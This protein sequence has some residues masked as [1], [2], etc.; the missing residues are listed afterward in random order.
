MNKS[1]VLGQLKQSDVINDV[2][3]IE[4]K[5]EFLVVRF[6]YK[7]DEDEL[8]AAR[9]YADSETDGKVDEKSWYDD[10]YI[11]YL[12]DISVDE[13][14]D[15]IEDMVE[16]LNLAAEYISYEP[17]RDDTAIE[18]IAV[19]TDDGREFDI[20]QVLDSISI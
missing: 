3:E 12:T 15:T 9:D 16:E 19:F 20:D 18:F 13:V 10:F 17:E 1:V 4:Y 11:P 2:E 8:E 14:R 6:F 7:F 5:P